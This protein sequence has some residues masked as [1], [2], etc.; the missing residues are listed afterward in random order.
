[1]HFDQIQHC[2]IA[3]IM[4]WSHPFSD[5]LRC[6][7]EGQQLFLASRCVP[8]CRCPNRKISVSKVK[9]IK[10]PLADPYG[11]YASL[12]QYAMSR[13]QQ[14][15]ELIYS[16]PVY[17]KGNCSKVSEYGPANR[18]GT[19]EEPHLFLVGWEVLQGN[20]SWLEVDYN[21]VVETWYGSSCFLHILRPSSGLDVPS[22][23]ALRPSD[24]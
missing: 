19:P 18:I 3:V 21:F 5:P 11:P 6:Q 22:W 12:N 8:R 4:T 2:S 7:A 24:A 1:M 10:N 14:N 20:T 9:N 23:R 13:R 17:L 15:S 16:P